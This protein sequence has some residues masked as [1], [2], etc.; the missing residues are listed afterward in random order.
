MQTLQAQEILKLRGDKA[1]FPHIPL[2]DVPRAQ[3]WVKGSKSEWFRSFALELDGLG[4]NPDS[5][6]SWLY[7]LC[8]ISFHLPMP[9][10]P[11][12]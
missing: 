2:T 12:P 7:G 9:Q 1:L 8:V 10:F 11:P 5:P 3:L 6:T 4:P